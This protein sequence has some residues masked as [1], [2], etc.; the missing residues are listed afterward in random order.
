MYNSAIYPGSFDPITKGHVDVIKR[1]AKMYDKLIVAVLINTQ[2][3]SLFTLEERCDM[4]EKSVKDIK[5]V[6][7]TA[8]SGLLANFCKEND[9]FTI[10]R[11]L[12][13]MSDF[14]NELQMANL[15]KF[16]DEDIETVFL[17]TTVNYSYVSSSNIKEIAQLGGSVENLVPDNVVEKLKNKF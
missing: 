4:I 14:E 12:R 1:A 15:N 13:A 11:G 9:I 8:F 2:K 3:K 6:E 10:V 5:N 17:A 7:V 16:L